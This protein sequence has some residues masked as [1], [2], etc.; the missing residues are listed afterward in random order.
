MAINPYQLVQPRQSL[1]SSIVERGFGPSV[2]TDAKKKGIMDE[3]QEKLKKKSLT[4][5]KR[6]KKWKPVTVALDV[7]AQAVDPITAAILGAFSGAFS[8]YDRMRAYQGLEDFGEQYEGMSFLDEY[9]RDVRKK[10]GGLETDEADVIISAGTQALKNFVSGKTSEALSGGAQTNNTY[11]AGP[12]EWLKKVTGGSG[13]E[14][15]QSISDLFKKDPLGASAEL[16]KLF[17]SAAK[18]IVDAR[19]RSDFD[20]SKYYGY[21]G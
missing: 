1:L 7:A 13:D 15:L 4:A 12:A 19:K 20:F 21:G 6:S 16:T 2:D 14:I 3:A 17:A 9:L 5:T 8:G 10:I 11:E 18:P